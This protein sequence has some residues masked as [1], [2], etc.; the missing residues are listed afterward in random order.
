[1]P[2]KRRRK[3]PLAVIVIDIVEIPLFLFFSGV[4]LFI[5]AWIY[6]PEWVIFELPV[7][8]KWLAL[9]F[10][11]GSGFALLFFL[12]YLKED[13]LEKAG[14]G[15]KTLEPVIEKVD[16]TIIADTFEVAETWSSPSGYG[17]TTQVPWTRIRVRHTGKV[18]C[19]MEVVKGNT[20][21]I[22]FFDKD[23]YM[24]WK[25]KQKELHKVPKK[26]KIEGQKVPTA[27]PK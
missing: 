24:G 15:I 11:G 13:Y 21:K 8:A 10:V 9:V 17:G 27:C 19:V 26:V 4:W 12:K 1:M 14:Y 6:K 7:W 22:R 23:A 20:R 3:K 16:K 2:T 18:P 25:K 5:L